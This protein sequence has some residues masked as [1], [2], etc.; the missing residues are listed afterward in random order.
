MINFLCREC[1]CPLCAGDGNMGKNIRC[2]ECQKMVPVPDPLDVLITISC[3]ECGAP[4]QVRSTGLGRRME[5]PGCKQ[6]IL[7]PTPEELESGTTRGSVSR[8][9][10]CGLKANPELRCSHCH[11]RFCSEACRAQHLKSAPHGCAM[12]ALVT[13]L[14]AIGLVGGSLTFLAGLF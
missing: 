5:C 1:G 6:S 14:V 3:P 13:I 2:P 8:C 7:T 4:A 11:A 9:A 12:T 10:V